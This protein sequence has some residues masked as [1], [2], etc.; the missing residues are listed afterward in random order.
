MKTDA[1][2]APQQFL[3][4]IPES[5]DKLYTT[6]SFD[7]GVT[8]GWAVIAVRK[9]AI[10]VY[11]KKI[12]S[13]IVWWSAGEFDGKYD[14]QA[15]EMLLLVDAWPD[16]RVVV[17]GFTL[18]KFSRDEELL[19]PVEIRAKLEYGLHLRNRTMITQQPSLAKTTISDDR[20]KALGFWTGL[21]PHARD[22]IRHNI[23]WLRR[24]KELAAATTRNK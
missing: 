22:A 23:T 7:P 12:L 4:N 17:E 9:A 2:V 20:L 13:N 6:V 3:D 5:N 24:A 10:K 1:F 15:D 21:S 8:T 16:A 18:R 19:S 11:T 14:S